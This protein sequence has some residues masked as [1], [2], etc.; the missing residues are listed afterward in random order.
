MP[1]LILALDQGTTSSRALIFDIEGNIRGRGQQAI[2]QIYP[3]AGWVEHDP[4]EIWNTQTQAARQALLAEGLSPGDI[5]A[6]GIANQRETVVLWD[7]RTGEPLY[8]AIVWQCRR[9]DALCRRLRADGL[10]PEI[11]ARTGLLLDPYFSATKL[12][13]LLRNVSGLEAR[14]RAGELAFGTIDSWLLWQLTDGRVHA[15]DMTNAAR[16]LLFNIHS[17]CWDPFLLD[18]FGIPAE[19]LPEVRPSAGL[20]GETKLLG[21]QLPIAAIAGDQHAALFGHGCHRPGEAK[22]TYG[23]GA[24]ALMNTGATAPKTDGRTLATIAWSLAP[25]H[26]DYALEGAIFIAGAVVKWLRDGLGIITETSEVEGL[27]RAVDDTGGVYLVPAFVGLGA[28]YWDAAAR[29]VIVGITAGT[30]RRHLARAAL[31][32]IAF[33]TTDVL[34]AMADTS[35]VALSALRVDGGASTNDL[36]LQI[37][38]DFLGVPVERPR[39]LETTALG[40]ASLAAYAT[41]LCPDIDHLTSLNPVARQFV[42]RI[43][44]CRRA[45][46]LADW[47]RAVDRCRDWALS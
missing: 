32:S 23:T 37:Q 40:A 43:D 46:R 41:G 19:V 33:Q 44:E 11:S 26:V 7:R 36:L 12:S 39:C 22:N 27:A 1:E 17:R 31:E 38:A 4:W 24:F 25:D 18:C 14:A 34:T 13:W 21:R 20:F 42:P 16:T 5:G 45:E 30:D 29:G 10:E 47:H 6:V 8:N 3:R 28:P 2:R 35:A 9:G 15:T